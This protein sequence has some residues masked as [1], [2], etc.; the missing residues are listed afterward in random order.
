MKLAWL[1]SYLLQALRR[2][3]V[4]AVG[5]PRR[6]HKCMQRL[7]T[8]T[9]AGSNP[10]KRDVSALGQVEQLEQLVKQHGKGGNSYTML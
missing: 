9:T 4:T 3:P 6:G 5:S 8:Y 2:E 10:K 7:P 1:D